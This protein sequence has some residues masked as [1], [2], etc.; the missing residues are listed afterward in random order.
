MYKYMITSYIF[1]YTI[2]YIIFNFVYNIREIHIS[3]VTVDLIF[4]FADRKNVTMEFI[5]R[6]ITCL[7]VLPP[8]MFGVS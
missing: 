1:K 6:A 2:L 4:I 5:S 7:G 3:L 8:P